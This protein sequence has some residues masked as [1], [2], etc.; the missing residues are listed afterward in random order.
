MSNHEIKLNGK[1]NLSI[2]NM[3]PGEERDAIEAELK[4]RALFDAG[5]LFIGVERLDD[6]VFWPKYHL[7]DTTLAIDGYEVT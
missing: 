4:V 7:P 5:D 1:E 3:P 2:F 6:D